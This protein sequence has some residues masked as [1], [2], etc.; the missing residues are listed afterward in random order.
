MIQESGNVD[1]GGRAQDLNLLA[2]AVLLALRRLAGKQLD[3]L[4]MNIWWCHKQRR[5]TSGLINGTTPPWEIT[6]SPSSL[7]NLFI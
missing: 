1:T 7:F 2:V 6:T 5:R 4:E 3:K